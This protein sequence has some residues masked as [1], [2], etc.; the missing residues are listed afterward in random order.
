MLT[1]LLLE[2]RGNGKPTAVGA[3]TGLVVGLVAITPACAFV[4][5]WAAALVGVLG[6]LASFAAISYKHRMR[7]DDALDVF[8]CHGVAG[9]VGALLTGALAW[10]TGQGAPVAQQVWVQ[11]ISVVVSL[12]Y[13]GAGSWVLLKLVSAVMP[14]RVSVAE[15]T[16]GMDLN[17]HRE[18]GYS[19]QEN[20]LS[21]PVF[22]GGD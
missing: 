18:K 22:L 1:W 15:E 9:I 14:L 16:T 21:A 11:L 13:A 4:T 17:A 2:S 7:S 8:A 3:A 12:V 6:A 19:E 5:P 10:T 20:G